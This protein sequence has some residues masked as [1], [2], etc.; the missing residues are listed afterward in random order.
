[1]EGEVLSLA[2]GGW[3]VIKKEKEIFFISGVLPGEI[4]EFSPEFKRKG[5]NFGKVSR[6]ISPSSFRVEPKCKYFLI[7]GGCHFQNLKYESQLIEK[8]KILKDTLEKIG[9][10]KASFEKP[11]FSEE[12]GYRT[13]VQFEIDEE[14]NTCFHR[15]NSGK[16]IKI[17]SCPV[18]SRPLELFLK[19]INKFNLSLKE[20]KNLTLYFSKSIVGRIELKDE[21]YFGKYWKELKKISLKGL[22]LKPKKGR[23][24]YFIK[25]E[26]NGYFLEHSPFSF[27]QINEK[28]N[29][30][31]V[32]DI[33]NLLKDFEDLR[34]LDAYA[35]AGNFSIPL[36]LRFKKVLALEPSNSNFYLLRRNK[37]ENG[38]ENLEVFKSNFE[39]FETGEKI[40]LIVLDPPR[41]G[42]GKKAMEKI[43]QFKPR[44]LIY[45]SCDPSTFARDLKI[46]SEKYSVE[47]IKLIDMFPQT[48]HIESMAFLN[49]K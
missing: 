36:S 15:L 30:L 42:L 12:Y 48:Y 17:D 8:E 49:S 14:G 18:L 29:K 11:I 23:G 7:C 32:E 41:E 31:L 26:F 44:F 37:E 43:F 39:E 34:I 20:A 6:I 1:M 5:V 33:F 3:G 47:F 4:V 19:R 24:K 35:G 22:W 27:M 28:V 25:R 2:F 46:L 21:D 45:I 10:I 13:K 40:E 16:L 38:I 9:K